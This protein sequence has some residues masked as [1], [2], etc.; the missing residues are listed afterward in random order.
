MVQDSGLNRDYL[1]YSTLKMMLE[2]PIEFYDADGNLNGTIYLN[3]ADDIL[4]IDAP[5]SNLS[6]MGGGA[7]G[8]RVRNDLIYV[9]RL[10]YIIGGG[11][12]NLPYCA[13]LG[14]P[15][16]H[17]YVDKSL[18][19]NTTLNQPVC[20]DST[21][22]ERFYSL[23][24]QVPRSILADILNDMGTP[25]ALWPFIEIGATTNVLDYCR[26]GHHL[27][28]SE[29]VS[30]WDTPPA[31]RNRLAY[32]TF[33]GVDELLSI[34]DHADFTFGD[35]AT[36]EAFSIICVF[37][38]TEDTYPYTL[39]GKYNENTP[40]REW[41]LRLDANKYPEFELYDENIDKYIGREDQTAVTEGTWY[42]LIVTYNGD[43]TCGGIKIY[44][45]GVRV[46]DADH[47]DAGYVAMEDLG[48]AVKIGCNVVGGGANGNFYLGGASLFGITQK[49]FSEDEIWV[50]NQRIRGMMGV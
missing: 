8:I 16:G 28:A 10:L 42:I 6:L 29:N 32:Y 30:A 49:E 25:M 15:T 27:V 39:I 18:G 35:G 43:S 12:Q 4:R 44:L 46:D 9:Y 26:R 3:P 22:L 1:K 19:W 48:A 40:A 23:E 50:L 21:N 20:Y 36:D 7:E 31:F 14:Y 13:F 41:I 2:N 5:G 33:N 45:D 11:I 38:A 34:A 17:A 37:N 47:T 24:G